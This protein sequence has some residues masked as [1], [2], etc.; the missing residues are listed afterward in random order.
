M[1]FSSP[2]QRK[3]AFKAKRFLNAA[4]FLEVSFSFSAQGE[5][6][7]SQAST[8]PASCQKSMPRGN[9]QR[10][11]PPPS[12]GPAADVASSL[13]YHG[14]D[15]GAP[16]GKK[17]LT[18]SCLGPSPAGGSRPQ[19][20]CL[21][22]ALWARGLERKQ[23]GP[24]QQ[25]LGSLQLSCGPRG[26]D[27]EGLHPQQ[28]RHTLPPSLQSQDVLPGAP[29]CAGEGGRVQSPSECRARPGLS[30]PRACAL[31]LLA[32]PFRALAS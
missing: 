2:A 4:Q 3:G 32:S 6:G 25:G 11:G 24:P 10:M 13:G 21:R 8:R 30:E 22:G 1:P 19:Q 23:R 7:S 31:S 17:P 26:T 16:A 5:E 28:P 18:P 14:E 29:P 12:H 15:E 20:A 9:P 27:P